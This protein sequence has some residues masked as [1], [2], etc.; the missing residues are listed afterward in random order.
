[1]KLTFLGTG[2]STGVPEIGCYCEVCTSTDARDARL[3]CS[4][5][6]EAGGQHILIDCGPDFRTQ[7]LRTPFPKIDAL[8]LTHKHYDH[9][10]GIDDL[11][12]FC[13]GK[14]IP[15][16]ADRETE[17]QIHSMYPY[18]FGTKKYPG[19]ANIAINVIDDSTHF[20]INGVDVL[21]IRVFHGM[22]PI[23]GYRF[24]K[25]AYITDMSYIEPSELE[26]LRGVEVLVINALRFSKPH[27]THQTVLE[28]LRVVE[29]IQPR[30]TYF[31]HMMHHIG[32]HTKIE[33][34]LPAG[35]HLAYDCLQIEIQ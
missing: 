26:K 21:P 6:L 5:M 12:P 23:L 25:L 35:V 32:L 4:A 20:S 10:G 19:T 24:G 29:Q 3:R 8:L 22:F 28:A 13:R 27:R 14:E 17:M 15:I 1:M 7:M 34:C 2:T 16:Y 33:K 9:T 30:E 18:C 11:R 31:T